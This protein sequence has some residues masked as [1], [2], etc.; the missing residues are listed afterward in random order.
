MSGF[1]VCQP[2]ISESDPKNFTSK[3][4]SLCSSFRSFDIE[5]YVL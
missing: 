1:W 5:E 3:G 4:L 2:G